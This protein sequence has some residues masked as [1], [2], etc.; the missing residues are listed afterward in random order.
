MRPA[1]GLTL[2]PLAASDVAELTALVQASRERLRRWLPWAERL[3]PAGTA[4]FV[5][6]ASAERRAGG[7]QQLGLREGGRLVGV[8]G[9]RRLDPPTNLDVGYWLGEGAEGR[10]LMTLACRGLVAHVF[11]AE[12]AHRVQIRAATG[13]ARSRRI[14]ERLGFRLEGI[15][16]EA[17][18]LPCGWVDHCVYGLTVGDWGRWRGLPPMAPAV[19]CP[20]SP[21]GAD[22]GAAPDPPLGPDP[23]LDA[24][25]ARYYEARA[26]E[27]DQWYERR[28][29][30]GALSTEGAWFAELADLHGVVDRFA[31]EAE[32]GS[33]VVDV[34]CGTGRWTAAL[35]QRRLGVVGLDQAPAMLAQA[36]ERLR[37]LGLRALLL[38]GDALRL[39]FPCAS[40]DGALAAFLFDHLD[41]EQRRAFCGE[42]RRV[43]RPGGRVLILDSRREPRHRA[44]VELQARRL[45]DGRTFRVRKSL[46]TAET[47]RSA[48]A[49][50]GRARTGE[51][52]HF[53]VWGEVGL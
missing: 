45:Q 42:L 30:Y 53:F 19:A 2:R 35:A 21:A 50:L 3:D 47:L 39:P 49:P 23:A 7:G 9:Y 32:V 20:A 4:A 11:A 16:R 6:T 43:V 12:G 13:N 41:L 29:A 15:L 26:P 34:G 8:I 33:T 28:G 31:A 44:D 22:A 40:L 36:G 52:P 24:E 1:P 10:G 17:E 38:Q 48:L 27:Y 5:R 14:P 18:Q 37:A 25:M 51:T 46:F